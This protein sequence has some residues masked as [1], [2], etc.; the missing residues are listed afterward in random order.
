MNLKIKCLAILALSVAISCNEAPKQKPN[1]FDTLVLVK[2]NVEVPLRYSAIVEGRNDVSVMPRVSGYIQSVDVSSGAKVRKGQVMFRIDD[3]TARNN[4]ATR[5]ADLMATEAQ[6]ESARLEYES[7]SNLYEKKIVSSY[8]LNTAKNDY[9]KAQAAVAQ[10]KAQLAQAELDLSYCT[11]TA[12][13][14]G[15]VGVVPNNPG[16]LVTPSS[17]LTTIAATSEM[18]V[19]FSVAEVAFA[20]IL[21]TF[22]DVKKAIEVAPELS[23]MLK[24]GV[25]YNHKGRLVNVSGNVD[26]YTGSVVFEAYFPNPE[27][28]LYSGIQGNVVMP[29]MRKGVLLVPLSAVVRIQD[30]TMV[31]KVVDN[32]AV[33]TMIELFEEGSAQYATVLSGLE[34]GDV[35]VS[36]G[37]AKITEGQQVVFPEADEKNQ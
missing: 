6:C 10:A 20:E 8:V 5:K 1:S 24:N 26:R 16:D 9:S 29:I 2:K 37:V 35:I 4:V 15:L 18:K 7:N 21:R 17:V 23:L 31:Y 14:D 32:K 12:P 11:I 3:R 13:V 19:L 28:M 34:E 25:E 33:S 30:K 22:G 36:K 27:G